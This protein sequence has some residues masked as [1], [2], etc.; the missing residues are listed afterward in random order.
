MVVST[1]YI[2]CE[3]GY[4]FSCGYWNKPGIGNRLTSE[5]LIKKK[6]SQLCCH[7][8][9]LNVVPNHFLKKLKN[10]GRIKCHYSMSRVSVFEFHIMN[11]FLTH[12][13]AQY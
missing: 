13:N 3:C 1:L 10:L 8:S 2:N 9:M 12:K 7:K 5:T 11:V 6:I 4:I